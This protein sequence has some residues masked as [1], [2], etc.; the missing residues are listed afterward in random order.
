[1]ASSAEA[2]ATA[3]AADSPAA[4]PP[5]GSPPPAQAP[6]QAAN[7]QVD[8]AHERD[9]QTDDGFEDGPTPS[10]GVPTTISRM[11][12]LTSIMRCC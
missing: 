6:A 7:I 1:M 11:S 3:A 8:A 12:I 10:T 5:T 9:D 2:P 4:S